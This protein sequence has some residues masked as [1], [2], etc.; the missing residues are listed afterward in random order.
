MADVTDDTDEA[1]RQL[2]SS[3]TSN[4]DEEHCELFIPHDP[5]CYNFYTSTVIAVYEP[6]N[7]V[8]YTSKGYFAI[9]TFMDIYGR[10]T[11]DEQSIL[12]N[13]HPLPSFTSNDYVPSDVLNNIDYF[14]VTGSPNQE[15]QIT[16]SVNYEVIP[17]HDYYGILQP[18]ADARGNP[19]AVMEELA[20]GRSGDNTF[21]ESI[22]PLISKAGSAAKDFLSSHVLPYIADLAPEILAALI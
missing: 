14:I 4:V 12:S 3:Y 2:A 21:W 15:Y 19:Q 6:L 1:I 18:V 20:T 10:H 9:S 16:F 13:T 11:L 8:Q 17:N 7:G 22:K 5:N